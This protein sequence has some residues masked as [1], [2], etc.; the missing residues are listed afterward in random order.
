MLDIENQNNKTAEKLLA[1]SPIATVVTDN[2]VTD[3]EGAVSQVPVSDLNPPP[4]MSPKSPKK[5]EEQL[6]SWRAP[7]EKDSKLID[8]SKEND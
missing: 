7:E 1:V 4:L 8:E 2:N 3:R 5:N 6:M